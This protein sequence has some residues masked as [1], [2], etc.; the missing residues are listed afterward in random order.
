MA[1]RPPITLILLLVLG[2]TGLGLLAVGVVT[3]WGWTLLVPG[4]VAVLISLAGASVIQNRRDKP[5]R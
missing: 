1:P 2:G 5:L 4:F 3:S